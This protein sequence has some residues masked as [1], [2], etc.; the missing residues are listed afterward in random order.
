M[1]WAVAGAAAAVAAVL[2]IVLWRRRRAE[3]A[4]WTPQ[5]HLAAIGI[6]VALLASVLTAIAARHESTDEPEDVRAYRE[7]VRAACVSLDAN[8]VPIASLP[9]EN[10]NVQR[11]VLV[12]A[13]NAT[14]DTSLGILDRLWVQP[15]PGELEA[16]VA[17][18]KE[19]GSVWLFVAR[20]RLQE[21]AAGLSDRMPLPAALA[22]L[23]RLDQE[24]NPN[25]AAFLG[26]MS[27][28]AGE[29]CAK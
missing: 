10:G 4:R 19:K 3:P 14:I 22:Y 11:D 26:A 15:A 1:L 16:A 8:A 9:D 27:S 5:D 29:T 17:E 7:H 21:T 24:N 2:I 20:G 12:D 13:V 23:Q 18:A 6:A 28:L 25:V